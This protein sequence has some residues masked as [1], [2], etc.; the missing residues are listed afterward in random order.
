MNIHGAMNK[1]MQHTNSIEAFFM[2]IWRRS[3]P[4]HWIHGDSIAAGRNAHCD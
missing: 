2:R 3:T 1:N 4:Q